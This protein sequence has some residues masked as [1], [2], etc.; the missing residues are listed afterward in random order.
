MPPIRKVAEIVVSTLMPISRAASGSWA[1]AR[2]ALPSRLRLMNATIRITSGIVTANETTSARWTTTPWI[3]ATSCWAWMRSSTLAREPLWGGRDEVVAPRRRAAEPQQADVLQHER[4]AD[5]G[6]QRG[7][8]GRVAQ[9]A[10]GHALDHHVEHAADDHREDQ[11]HDDPAGDA[12]G[13]RRQADPEDARPELRR[14]ERADHEDVAVG[15]VDQLDDPV[16]QR[17]ADR[18]QRE[19]RA[20]RQA[21]EEVVGQVRE[22]VLGP[23]E[24]LDAVEDRQREKDDD[25]AVLV[26]KTAQRRAEAPAQGRR[27][28]GG[29]AGFHRGW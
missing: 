26:G 4:H 7:E 9:R 15:E 10:V 21:R 29:G 17:V 18:D 16:D 27:R 3:V 22:V 8:L 5:R 12:E 23:G 20:V 28:G 14:R 19:D 1:V 25:Q 13:R 6:D 11:R 2:I 24:V